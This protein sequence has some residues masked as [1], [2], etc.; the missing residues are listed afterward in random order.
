VFHWR[1]GRREFE[2]LDDA[3]EA[4]RDALAALATHSALEAG[5]A[6]PR[7]RVEVNERRGYLA[8]GQLDLI[9]VHIEARA[10]GRPAVLTAAG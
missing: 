7:V 10:S 3:V 1:D 2:T 9:E 4:A 5:A 8:D 6:E